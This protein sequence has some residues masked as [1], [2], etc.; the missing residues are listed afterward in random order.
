MSRSEVLPDFPLLLAGVSEAVRQ[1]LCLAG[2]PV[3]VFDESLCEPACGD[4]DSHR[5][6]LCD[7]RSASSM[8]VV[9][10]IRQSSLRTIDLASLRAAQ[11]GRQTVAQSADSLQSEESTDRQLISPLKAE[12]E[13]HSGAWVRLGDYPFPFQSALCRLND[14]KCEAFHELEGLFTPTWSVQSDPDENGD[15]GVWLRQQYSSGLPVLVPEASPSALPTGVSVADAE[16]DD[17]ALMWRTTSDQFSDWWRVRQ[18]FSLKVWKKDSTYTIHAAGDFDHFPPTIELW[19]GNHVATLPLPPGNTTVQA[20]G[21]AFA[22]SDQRK[23]G[24]FT[25]LRKLHDRVQRAMATLEQRS[26]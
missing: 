1:S 23:P 3:T 7:S 25:S 24:G 12:I 4:D 6:V 13:K 22:R 14:K 20:T 16:R 9:Q 10:S 18:S 15:P 21:L 17:F 26:A 2:V 19:H 11:H 8:S 5:F